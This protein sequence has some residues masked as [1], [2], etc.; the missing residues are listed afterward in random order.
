MLSSRS[1]WNQ[2]E[3]YTLTLIQAADG[4]SLV[5]IQSNVKRQTRLIPSPHTSQQRKV[6]VTPCRS[7]SDTPSHTYTDTPSMH[8]EYTYF[9]I[10]S[11]FAP[12]Y[13]RYYLLFF[14]FSRIDWSYPGVTVC[15]RLK[16]DLVCFFLEGLMSN[17][18]LRQLL[19]LN[20]FLW[21]II[22][23]LLLEKQ[24]FNFLQLHK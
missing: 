19:K 17:R 4:Y 2:I 22:F 7:L 24:L 13:D 21:Y 5:Y 23:F 14:P 6:D 20:K 3:L 9:P 16:S 1:I 18:S 10:F 15:P 11:W 12:S 8:T